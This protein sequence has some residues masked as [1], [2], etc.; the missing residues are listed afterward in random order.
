MARERGA[1]GA[2]AMVL[3]RWPKIAEGVRNETVWLK[4]GESDEYY[5]S[6]VIPS[7]VKTVQVL[8]NVAATLAATSPGHK[9]RCM[10]L[11]R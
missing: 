5:F 9:R 2:L 11:N 8:T 1:S 7:D 10:T 6:F 3:I 4:P